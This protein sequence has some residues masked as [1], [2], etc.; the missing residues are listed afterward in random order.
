MPDAVAQ[1]NV[2]QLLHLK[3]AFLAREPP[4]SVLALDRYSL[5]MLVKV[6]I[7]MVHMHLMFWPLGCPFYE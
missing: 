1:D 6:K 4:A 3:L 7:A 5:L 2:E